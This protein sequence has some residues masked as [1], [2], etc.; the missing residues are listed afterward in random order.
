[1]M[2]K[3]DG[4]KKKRARMAIDRI[5]SFLPSATELL[6]EFGIGDKL[7][8]VTH[9]CKH[10]K[11]AAKK[12]QVIRSVVDS[13][14]LSS[15]EI[16]QATCTSLSEGRDI[17]QIDEKNLKDAS[18]DLI[19]LQDTCAACAA[20]TGQADRAVQILDKRPELHSIDPHNV[21]E[22]IESVE[23]LGEIL[24]LEDKAEEIVSGLEKRI[25]KIKKIR[26]GPRLKI[27]AI[28]WMEPFFTAGHW[29]PEMIEIAGGQSLASRTGERSRRMTFDEISDAAPD[30]IILMPCGFDTKR[31]I[32]EYERILMN[33]EK[34]N[35]LGAVKRNRVFAVDADSFF[36]K[37]SIRTIQGIEILARIINPSKTKDLKVPKG[38]F[39]RIVKNRH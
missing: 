28:E 11:E 21:Q 22:I 37:P 14:N 29:V 5:V 19:I 1:M 33:D 2:F 32:S 6:F 7:F 3:D 38:T 24:E 17:F 23:K 31:T 35:S 13:D 10:P 4:S 20:H 12:P 18:P 27:A 36:S 9:Q 34:W 30:L 25:E 16:D 15:K 39:A 26:M 8:G